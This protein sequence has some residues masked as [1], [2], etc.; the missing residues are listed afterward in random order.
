M[1][2]LPVSSVYN[3]N[4]INKT[5]NN[6]Q[7]SRSQVSFGTTAAEGIV[8]PPSQQ[9]NSLT[10]TLMLQ[11]RQK[12]VQKQIIKDLKN[13]IKAQKEMIEQ[14][15]KRNEFLEQQLKDDRLDAKT[16]LGSQPPTTIKPA[17]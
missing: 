5:N 10:Q 7:Q 11:Q 12:V 2:I 8:V 9:N 13:R 1:Q 3:K 6:K 4:G 16:W 17:Q 14:L 15:Q